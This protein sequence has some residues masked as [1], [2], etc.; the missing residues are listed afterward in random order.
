MTGPITN[1]DVAEIL[2]GLGKHNEAEALRWSEKRAEVPR[3]DLEDSLATS[4]E[5][6][7]EAQT[8]LGQLEDLI[9]KPCAKKWKNL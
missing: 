4:E 1:N 9:C 7:S 8:L 2:D 3:D 5:E 6:R